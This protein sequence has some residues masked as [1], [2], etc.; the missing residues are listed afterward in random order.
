MENQLQKIYDLAVKLAPH[1]TETKSE[2]EEILKSNG[3]QYFRTMGDVLFTVNEHDIIEGIGFDW[4]GNF[5]VWNNTKFGTFKKDDSE[6]L[7]EK[8]FIGK[9]LEQ[10]SEICKHTNRDFRVIME[11]GEGYIATMDFRFDR[12]NFEIEKG[13][14][15]KVSKG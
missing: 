12:V 11:D 13:I 3:G 14:I 2:L 10:A 9:T 5:K 8:E 15:T 4:M 7:E 6:T 1:T